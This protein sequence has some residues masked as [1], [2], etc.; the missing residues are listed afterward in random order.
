[1]LEKQA[2]GVLLGSVEL[3]FD[4]PDLAGMTVADVLDDPA[5]FVGE[6]L[7]DPIE[8]IEDGRC[9]A[10]VMWDGVGPPIIN[11]FAHGHSVYRLRY[12]AAAVQAR[13]AHA[14]A[15]DV[16]AALVRLVAMADLSAVEIDALAHDV[17][18]CAG[19]GVRAVKS[20]LKAG[21][22]AQQAQQAE[23]ARERRKAMR[24]DPRPLQDRP[25]LDAEWLPVLGA[26]D[27][28][29]S[30]VERVRRPRRDI[31][32][33]LARERRMPI[34]QTHAFNTANDEGDDA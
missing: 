28:V 31:D 34:A 27:E 30:A 8:G 12:D 26:L 33:T 21:L 25:A 3:P 22:A 16:V 5:R 11:S 14:P 6:T 29:A 18:K 15:D 10:K 9:K 2:N 20:T 24:S 32:G 4:D 23:A 13:I 7:A 1:M 17:A 19:V